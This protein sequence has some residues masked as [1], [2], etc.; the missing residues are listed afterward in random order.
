MKI[1]Y[2]LFSAFSLS[3]WIASAQKVDSLITPTDT[4]V[5]I[6]QPAV[7]LSKPE[8]LY[9]QAVEKQGAPSEAIAL[10]KKALAAKTAEQD[11]NWVGNIHLAMAKLFFKVNDSEQG[12]L[13]LLTA[14]NIFVYSKNKACH[15]AIT[16]EIAGI[17]E[18]NK[19]W[20]EAEKYY[21]LALKQQETGALGIEMPYTALALSKGYLRN[22]DIV[23]AEKYLSMAINQFELNRERNKRGEAYLL[24]A[25]IKLKQRNL[26]FTENLILKRALPYYSGVGLP[27]G[28]MICFDILGSIYQQ[29]KRF[30]EAKWFYLQGLTLGKATSDANGVV[31]ALI[32]LSKVKS[33]IGDFQSAAK[34]LQEAEA[35][36][37]KKNSLPLMANV[38]V[39][40]AS[41]NK[42]KQAKPVTKV[43]AAAPLPKKVI[44]E[45]VSKTTVKAGQL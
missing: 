34:D 33:S 18:K 37:K 28:K 11:T 26:A 45:N 24:L 32:N 8:M 36:A 27:K 17:Y 25:D 2:F 7:K 35:L 43:T 1:L 29:Q 40:Y 41:Y 23:K 10:Y 6:K 38:K 21:L 3:P 19:D 16:E 20:P 44:A 39:A 13:E 42:A 12:F 14:Q 31:M 22:K 30:S 9:K 5:F 15:A 4:L